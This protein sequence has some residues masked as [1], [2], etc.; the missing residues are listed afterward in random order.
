MVPPG[1]NPEA[2][3]LSE[4]ADIFF[5]L[6]KDMEAKGRARQAL[7][8]IPPFHAES[9]RP[10]TLL[11]KLFSLGKKTHESLENYDIALKNIE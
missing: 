3:L 5:S 2:E 9:I 8:L 4:A 6:G 1:G 11:I 7:E 10:L